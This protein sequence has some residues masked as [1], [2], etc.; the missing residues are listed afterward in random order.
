MPALA[1]PAFV[2]LTI[3]VRRLA[4]TNLIHAGAYVGLISGGVGGIG[5]ALHCHDDSLAF[6]AVAYTL[7][8][9]EMTIL[10]ALMGPRILHW[11]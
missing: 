5:Y 8:I 2:I 7:A 4:P 9:S 1:L 11:R 10:G 3:A 6:V